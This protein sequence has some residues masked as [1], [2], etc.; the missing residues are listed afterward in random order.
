MNYSANKM[1]TK[2]CLSAQCIVVDIVPL[3]IILCFL[4]TRFKKVVNCVNYK[5]KLKQSNFERN[6]EKILG[7][8]HLAN[9]C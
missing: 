4:T 5:I 6:A 7:F 9:S 2:H 8:E 3:T 1:A